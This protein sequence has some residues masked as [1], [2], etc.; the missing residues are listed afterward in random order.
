M[1]PTL[2]LSAVV[3]WRACSAVLPPSL[4]LPTFLLML[5]PVIQCATACSTSPPKHC[6]LKSPSV[7]SHYSLFTTL[8]ITTPLSG[9]T[10]ERGTPD[11]AATHHSPSPPLSVVVLWRV[12]PLTSLLFPLPLPSLPPPPSRRYPPQH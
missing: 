2:V 5:S 6:T 11:A 1:S 4:I 10:A 12:S 9:C 3:L 7:S 8:A